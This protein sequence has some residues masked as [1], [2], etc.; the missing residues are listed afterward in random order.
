[1]ENLFDV[2]TLKGKIF[3]EI[4]KETEDK[5]TLFSKKVFLDIDTKPRNFRI[6]STDPLV[7]NSIYMYSVEVVLEE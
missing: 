4:R 1:M 2:K 3:L 6:K 7:Y 5:K